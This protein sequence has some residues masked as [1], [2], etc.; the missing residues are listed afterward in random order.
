MPD[1]HPSGDGS[2]PTDEALKRVDAWWTVLLVDPIAAPLARRL[3]R[4]SSF[5][6]SRVTVA[7]HLLG[8]VSAVAFAL[9]ALV[10]GAIVFEMRF[11]FDCVD[12]KLAR[13]RGTSS[14]VGAYLDYVGDLLVVAVNL[15]AIGLWLD[16]HADAHPA[17]GLALVA[18]FLA[19]VAV[20]LTIT[21][22][23]D[24]RPSV[25][26]PGSV[27]AWLAA[28]RLAPKPGRIEAEH[29]LCFVAPLLAAITASSVPLEAAAVAIA[30]YFGVSAIR[31][32]QFGIGLARTKDR[33]S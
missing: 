27:A 29:L 26:P 14:N 28:R 19:R 31:G 25:A 21:M 9:D 2:A 20:G 4:W 6:P 15:V 8:L 18:A 11:V 3:N 17:I 16:W 30:A 12:G 7:A 23:Y 22:A 24:W 5:T 1:I 33:G 10:V 32:F 13:L